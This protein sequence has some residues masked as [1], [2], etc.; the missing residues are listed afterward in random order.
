MRHWALLVAL[1][2]GGCTPDPQ[3]LSAIQAR[4]T[5]NVATING[6]TTSYL[7]AHGPQGAQYSDRNSV[8]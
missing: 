3:S 5:L 6:Q 7:G 8:V 4:G 2:L 1:M